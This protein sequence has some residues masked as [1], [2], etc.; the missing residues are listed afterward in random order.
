MTDTIPEP[1]SEIAVIG[2]ACRFPG[3]PDTASFW[4][5]LAEGREG[6]HRFTDEELEAVP[7]EL[8]E[9]T[10]FV[11]AAGAL[12]GIDLFDAALFGLSPREAT[13]M[14]PQQ[15]LFLECGWHALE[16]AGWNRARAETNVGVFAGGSSTGY[17]D[18]LR[19]DRA[20]VETVGA[21]Q[22]TIGNEK[23]HLAPRL[24]YLLDLKGPSV[25]VQ[26]ACSTSLVAV[27]LACQS[28][29]QFESDLAL[30]GGAS[31]P[32]HGRSGYFFQEGGILSPDGHCRAFDAAA[33]GTVPAG[34]VGVV[35]LKRLADAL[36]DG[37][38]IRAVIRGSAINNDGAAKVGYTAP[39]VEGQ[40]RVVEEAQ[41]LA[42]VEPGEIS[43]IE[44]H[45][46]GTA[47]GDPIEIEALNQAFAALGDRL[48]RATCPVGSVK[49]NLGHADAAAGIAGLIKTILCLEH[50]TLVPS[51]H[52]E[53]PNPGVDF[54]GG[55]FFVHTEMAPWSTQAQSTERRIA[56]VSSF[57]IGGTN[58]HVI[59]EEAPDPEPL[60]DG[61]RPWYP[62]MLS[63]AGEASLDR[64]RESLG[65]HLADTVDDELLL[66][67]VAA[68][69]ATGRRD[70][71]WRWSATCANLADLRTAL[72]G[73][74]P[75]THLEAEASPTVVFV[76][77]GQGAHYPHLGLD[78]Y[79]LEPVFRET[80]DTCAELLAPHLDLEPGETFKGLLFD[81]DQ[82]ARLDEAD[83]WQ[84]TVF[85]VEFAL[86]TLWISWGLRPA[87]MI[88]HSLGEFV[89]ATLAGVLCLE[90]ALAL[91]ARRGRGVRE[92]PPG[93]MLALPVDEAQAS[94]WATGSIALAAVNDAG[95]SVLSGPEDD[96][97]RLA[98]ELAAHNPIRLAGNR[99][100]HSSM[101]E[102]L[103]GELEQLTAGFER[104][105]AQIP[106]LSNVTGTWWSAED[107][108]DTHYWARH[109]RS[110]V[111]FKDGLD[112]LA[113]EPGRV[114]LEVGPGKVLT[115]LAQRQAAGR[116]RTV[117]SLPDDDAPSARQLADALGALWRAGIDVD[118][119]AFFGNRRRAP[120]PLYPFEHQS[121]WCAEEG[122]VVQNADPQALN[123]RESAANWLHTPVWKQLPPLPPQPMGEAL[124]GDRIWLV[125]CD[126]QGFGTALVR[127]LQSLEQEV[128]QVTA[129]EYLASPRSDHLEIRPAEADD[130]R[131]LFEEL[132]NRDKLPHQIVHAWGLD[133]PTDE[134][135]A[136][137]MGFDSLLRIAQEMARGAQLEATRLAVLTTGLY[138]F[139]RADGGTPYPALSLGAVRVIPKEISQ[140]TC[141]LLDLAPAEVDTADGRFFNGLLAEMLV[142]QAPESLALRTGNRWQSLVER[143]PT[144]A[145]PVAPPWREGE[146]W[147]VVNGLQEIGLELT[148]QLVDV[149]VRVALLDRSF[150]PP[151]EEWESWLADE[152]ND[153]RISAHIRRLKDLG[154]GVQVLTAHPEDAARLRQAATAAAESSPVCGLIYLV[155]EGDTA[156]IQTKASEEP[157]EELGRRLREAE[158][159][160]NLVLGGD[161]PDLRTTL[162]FS[163]NPT[164]SA[165][166]GQVEQAAGHAFLDH[167]ADDLERRGAK[168][169]VTVAWGT[170]GWEEEG[171]EE[172][173]LSFI[174]EQLVEKRRLFGTSPEECFATLARALATGLSRLTVST[175][176][177]EALLAQQSLFTSE[178]FQ[179]QIGQAAA[180]APGSQ[181]ARPDLSTPYEAPRTEVEQ[182]LAEE[183]CSFFG[184]EEIG[185]HD[186]FF[187][188][189]GHSLLAVQVIN[190]VNELFATDLSLQSF[191]DTPNIA[192][193][194]ATLERSAPPDE[195]DAEALAA[196]LE[197]IEGLSADEVHEALE[198]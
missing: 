60:R 73:E 104:G 195:D 46:T 134:A 108:T 121:Y 9:R 52:Y 15:R 144:A 135:T 115:R 28:L 159:L 120:L 64:L 123:V 145:S 24:S 70:L 31:V 30:A 89:A 152:R 194:A 81:P 69:L 178:F 65:E 198:G 85:A 100:F 102:P 166:L 174:E 61:G 130:F 163:S 190:R 72:A 14:D 181:H 196:L 5:L 114:L 143:L 26:T 35:V 13:T 99:A 87:A 119:P 137:T 84:P 179:Q 10:D 183:W 39:S 173:G 141:Q 7:Q 18:L 112:T 54:A 38:R 76:F 43:Y 186:S 154:D 86:A 50:R 93:A 168:G 75:A 58:A 149:G 27:H 122:A 171:A 169:V 68:T 20:L 148:R 42:D 103:M 157:S 167:L 164:E 113:A 172:G 2:L 80:I 142:P 41:S 101:V 176:D 78:L 156:L 21:M 128:F 71:P 138:D 55:P 126:S 192:A 82:R 19:A 4:R 88:G 106:F 140:L 49:T 53:T 133:H 96:I 117:A 47:L 90:D 98:E 34:G 32:T 107:S 161:L 11:N 8:R 95:L 111:R 189:G 1:L 127:H 92:L 22:L 188:L 109:L 94:Q 170:R 79:R 74:Q 56:G 44:A 83:L 182:L 146:T 36:R 175:R 105:A 48:P 29:L 185:I 165:G 131:A 110:T 25:P 191:F 3:A 180:V 129:G 177:Y 153:P 77:P 66:A 62:V 59:V 97:E 67:D 197:E 193:L 45:G 136:R 57:G 40:R 6:I 158:A 63:A 124:E 125:F 51:L 91:V 116:Y 132:R 17:G 162:L 12:D 187:E 151:R 155:K 184:L 147:M 139:L 150:F 33:R 37:D 16:D 118:W 23:D 160:A